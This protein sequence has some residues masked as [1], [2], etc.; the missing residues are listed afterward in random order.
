M[1]TDV[2]LP[3]VAQGAIG[4]EI[5][6][7]DAE[8]ARPHRTPER[9]GDRR[10]RRGRA[11][12]PRRSSTARAAR[13]SPGYAELRDGA[14]AHARRDPDARR[15]RRASPLA[16][17]GPRHSGAAARRGDRR[18]AARPCRPR[19]FSRA[20]LMHV[21]VTRPEPDAAELQG[22][23]RGARARGRASS[24]C[25]AIEPLPIEAERVRRRA[26]RHRDE[27]QRLAGACRERGARGGDWR[28]RSSRVGPG[29]AELA[30]ELGFQRVIAGEGSARDL[31]PL[32][33]GCQDRRARARS[34]TSPAR[35]S[36]S[37]SPP[38][39]APAAS[40]CARSSPIAPWPRN[41][42]DACK[43]RSAIAD[44]T[45]DAVILMSPRTATIFAE[46]VRKAGPRGAGP[47]ARLRVPVGKCRRRAT[48]TSH[49]TRV[50]I[51]VRPNSS[52]IL[53]AVGP[54]GNPFLRGVA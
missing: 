54:G 12:L 41:T 19:L 14:A 35:R 40:R 3:A 48:A 51:A 25:C 17:T 43:R 7:D 6:A 36:P 16:R 31:V 33:L 22:A 2:M 5:R 28:F 1:H 26:R 30:R 53:E 24:R 38:S 46:L 8:T 13:P 45:L 34:C 9:R 29:T 44:G 39:F 20:R 18:R 52:A 11:R 15:K 10:L 42:L 23:A 32:I 47:P 21:L 50:N 4:I 27:P 37:I 49:P